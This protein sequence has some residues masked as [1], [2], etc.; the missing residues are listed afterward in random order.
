[1]GGCWERRGRDKQ[2]LPGPAEEYEGHREP[3]QSTRSDLGVGGPPW[4]QQECG[5]EGAL[6]ILKVFRVE[7]GADTAGNQ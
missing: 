6:D 2:G 5:L 7:G 4:L 1:M 3:L